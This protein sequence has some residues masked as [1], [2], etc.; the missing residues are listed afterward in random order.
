MSQNSDAQ[1]AR[2]VRLNSLGWMIQRIAGR[3]DRAMTRRLSALGLNL[4]QFAVMMTL[5]EKDGQ[6]QAEIGR[7]FQAPAYAISRALDH[8]EQAG[9]VTR[10][11][12]AQS[13]RS[14]VVRITAAG[15]ELGPTLFALVR[16][17]NDELLSDFS[18]TERETLRALLIR[19]V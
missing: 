1:E 12:H 9:L 10:A 4:L 5:L 18:E 6:T 8:L 14:H 15:R 3:I 7:I 13:R 17:M 16:E 19:L 11:A 2:Q